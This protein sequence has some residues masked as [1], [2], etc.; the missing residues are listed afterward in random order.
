MKFELTI[1]HRFTF[2]P[3]RSGVKR[4]A[5]I[6]TI[7]MLGIMLGTTALILTLSIV[8]GFSD[9][10]K[11]KIVGFG[12]HIQV[13][14]VGGRVFDLASSPFDDL[15]H[16]SNVDALS[17]FYQTDVILKGSRED[18]KEIFIEPAVLKGIIPSEDVSFIRD[19]ITEGVYF[20]E[21]T[22]A[23]VAANELYVILGKKLAQRI[24]AKVGSSVLLMSSNEL[25]SANLFNKNLRLEDAL[26]ML[27]LMNG[28]VVGI[29]E[30]GLAQGFDETMVFAPYFQLETNFVKKGSV[31]GIDIRTANIDR[32]GETLESI[33]N[34]MSYPF[35]ARSIYDIYYNIF[36]W[37]RLQENIIPMLLVTITVVAGFNIVS[38]LLIMVLDKKQEIGLLMSMGVSER[39]VRTVFVSQAMILSGAGI[40]LGNLLAFGLSMLEQLNHFIPLSEEVYF[41]NAVPI[42][43]K[44]ENYVFVSVIAILIT[45]T[46]SYIP[47][48]IGSKIKPIESIIE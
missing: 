25:E 12:S 34:E 39:N 16:V 6:V 29:Y 35:I 30:T 18:G 1:A 37:L 32:I 45:L 48:H 46:T 15:A 27:R 23:H 36:A 33:S 11:K 31:S 42:V 3:S 13:T 26:S 24:G 2:P 4:P 38:T 10:I 22:G 47:S 44:I 7:A 9:E 40:L 14:Q 28:R 5:F 21:V 19:K 17:P 43:I 41:I 20:T 8:Q